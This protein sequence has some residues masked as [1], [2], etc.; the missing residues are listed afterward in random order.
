MS[1]F[2]KNEGMVSISTSIYINSAPSVIQ[3]IQLNELLLNISVM[4]RIVPAFTRLDIGR[5]I[6]TLPVIIIAAYI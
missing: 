6:R 2:A 1:F 3:K 4:P 5:T